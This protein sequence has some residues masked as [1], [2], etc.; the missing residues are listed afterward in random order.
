MYSDSWCFY[1][2]NGLLRN[3]DTQLLLTFLPRMFVLLVCSPIHE[4]EHAWI[5]Y[6]LVDDTAKL[7]GRITLIPFKHLD[8]LGS[9]MILILGIGYWV[10]KTG[11]G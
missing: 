9:I 10:R 4:C 1:N 8:F 2:Q 6:K 11:A 7:Q 3:I 5:A